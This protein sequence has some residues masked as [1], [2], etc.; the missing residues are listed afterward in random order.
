MIQHQHQRVG[1]FIDVQNMYYSARHLFNRKVNFGNIVKTA[2]GD[3][4]LIR[5]IA[6]VVSTKT[7]EHRPF[8]EALINVGIETKE[9]ELVEFIGGQKKADWDVGITVDAIRLGETLDVIVLVSGDGDFVSLVEYLQS[10]GKIVEVISFRETTSSKLVEQVGI[11]R[12]TNLSAQKRL[13]LM[14]GAYKKPFEIGPETPRGSSDIRTSVATP[15]ASHPNSQ[16]SSLMSHPSS[17]ERR[18]HLPPPTPRPLMRDTRTIRPSRIVTPIQTQVSVPSAK[19]P[20]VRRKSPVS[21][22]AKPRS[23][24]PEQ[25]P[26]DSFSPTERY[27]HP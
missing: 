15:L 13:F 18:D 11:A 6:Y 3:R 16:L 19:K 22:N 1:V 2:A 17:R 4:Q 23:R 27:L 21:R 12:Y 20:V 7:D 26:D 5:A 9:K 8:F 14:P 25:G 10:K 24:A